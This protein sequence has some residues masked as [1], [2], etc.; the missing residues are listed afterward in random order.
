M[1]RPGVLAG[2]TLLV[3]VS[4]VVPFFGVVISLALPFATH[5]ARHQLWRKAS[6]A[7]SLGWSWIAWA[8]LWW[9]GLLSIFAPFDGSEGEG[10]GMVVSTIWLVIPLCAPAGLAAVLLPA[11]AVA[12]ISLTGLLGA[13]ATERVWAWVAALWLAPWVHH[14]VFSLVGP[15]YI[16]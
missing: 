5:A 4:F 10:G 13:T 3:L 6:T 14:A 2:I 15:E 9:P 8:G 16:C 7:A 1:A 12:A 11:V